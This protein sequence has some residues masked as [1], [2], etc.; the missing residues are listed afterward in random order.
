[1]RVVVGHAN[2]DFDAY[3]S[4]VA[5]T[6]LFE[7]ARGVFLGTQNANVRAFHNLHEDFVPFVDLRGL[8]LSVIDSVVMV[9]TRDPSR[10]GELG[11]V[12]SRPGVE[13]IVYDHHRRQEGD[14]EGV[15]D[16]SVET[17]ATTTILVGELKRRG[18]DPSPLEATLYLLGIHEDTG[19]LTYPGATA[20][21]A[22]AVAWLMARGADLDVLDRFL[23]RALDPGQRRIL[24]QLEDSLEVWVVNGQR[25]AVATATAEEYVDS[26]GV[27]T[28]YVVE[29][30]GHRVAI[31][32]IR[33]P[34]RTQVVARSRLAEVDVGAVMDRLGGGGHAQAAS[35]GFRSL[36]IEEALV[37]VREAR[38]RSSVCVKPS[39]RR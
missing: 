2:P 5:A 25:I 20:L 18:I 11:A 24:E 21:D 3:A 9:D 35:A 30:M 33:M 39:R 31:A 16:R 15:D 28:H 4:T 19:S 22:D 34:E 7:G 12:V 17:G 37:R 14:L 1:M 26:A 10:I 32:V 23:A 27:L 36:G 8:D 6:R 38:R 13:V 29:D